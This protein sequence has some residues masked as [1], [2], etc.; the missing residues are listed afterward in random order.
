MRNPYYKQI[1]D[2][3]TLNGLMKIHNNL[4]VNEKCEIEIGKSPEGDYYQVKFKLDGYGDEIFSAYSHDMNIYWLIGI[5]TYEKL[6]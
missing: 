3:L 4:Y 5:L 6:L 2:Y 1:E